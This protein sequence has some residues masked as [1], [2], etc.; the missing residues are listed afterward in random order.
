MD[1]SC[2]C[3]QHLFSSFWR[4][5][6]YL[7]HQPPLWLP[8][9]FRRWTCELCPR[10]KHFP[11]FPGYGDCFR[12][13]HMPQCVFIRGRDTFRLDSMMKTELGLLK[14]SCYHEAKIKQTQRKWSWDRKKE[15]GTGKLCKPLDRTTPG[16]LC[17]EVSKFPPWL[18]KLELFSVTCKI[19]FKTES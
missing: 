14:P 11:C 4:Q 15:Q 13:R 18:S 5:C 2:L 12:S 3:R 1:T 17:T 9:Q 8:A 10:N 19:N 7:G 16:I 6:S